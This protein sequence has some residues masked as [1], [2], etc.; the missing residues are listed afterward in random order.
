MISTIIASQLG[1]VKLFDTVYGT[2]YTPVYC[3]VM[4][5]TMSYIEQNST[6]YYMNTGR[7]W[8]KAKHSLLYIK[9]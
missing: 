9:E 1:M 4:S 6:K 8:I 3:D 2:S 5:D 7:D